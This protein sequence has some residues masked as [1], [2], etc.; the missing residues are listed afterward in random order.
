MVFRL[1]LNQ[2][3]YVHFLQRRGKNSPILAFSTSRTLRRRT[4]STG[5]RMTADSVSSVLP[6]VQSTGRTSF[7]RKDGHTNKSQP[8]AWIECGGHAKTTDLYHHQEGS[9]DAAEIAHM[10]DVSPPGEIGEKFQVHPVADRRN[11]VRR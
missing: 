1:F 7:L 8:P 5:E 6:A 9:R 3:V 4:Q 2:E 10:V 11:F